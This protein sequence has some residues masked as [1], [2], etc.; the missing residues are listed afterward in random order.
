MWIVLN[1]LSVRKTTPC[2]TDQPADGEREVERVSPGYG[3]PDGGLVEY[4]I[5][6]EVLHRVLPRVLPRVL[7]CG[8]LDGDVITAPLKGV[9]FLGSGLHSSSRSGTSRQKLMP[10]G[11]LDVLTST[12]E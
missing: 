6:G 3:V 2:V 12:H 9:V 1:N 8:W 5:P 11:P 7:V 4:L 10:N